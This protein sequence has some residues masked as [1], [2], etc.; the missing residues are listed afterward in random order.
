MKEAASKNHQ[1][2]YFTQNEKEVNSRMQKLFKYLLLGT[3]LFPIFYFV[4]L[5]EVSG[6][7]ICAFTGVV[8]GLI[9]IGAYSGKLVSDE[10]KVKWIIVNVYIIGGTIIFSMI[11]VNG[12]FMVIAPIAAA[13]LY[14]NKKL[15]I[16]TLTMTIA[17]YTVGDFV[18][19][20]L[21]LVYESAYKWIPL[22]LFFY[23]IQFIIIGAIL[24][25]LV[26]RTRLMVSKAQE[27]TEKNQEYLESSKETAQVVSKALE[28][29]TSNLSQ[30]NEIIGDVEGSAENMVVSSKDIVESAQNTSNIIKD[31]TNDIEKVVNQVEKT[32]IISDKMTDITNDNKKNISDFL[33]LVENIKDKSNY[34]KECM[35]SL[36]GMI[37]HIQSILEN[38]SDISS[39]T[40]LLALNASI[41]AARYGE[42]GKGFSV[43]AEEVKKLALE[44]N[45][46]SISIG[47]FTGRLEDETKKAVNAIDGNYNMILE[48]AGYISETNKSF[49]YLINIQNNMAE[50]INH[51][52]TIMDEFV[53]KTKVIEENINVLM[54]KNKNNDYEVS[55]IRNA[56]IDISNKSKAIE[57]GIDKIS[58]QIEY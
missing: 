14:Y 19:S 12:I 5:L 2:N 10:R 21:G 38:I 57:E 6:I 4:G 9:L 46:Y 8:I 29:A 23:V 51:V 37:E 54:E 45:K 11:S 31:V 26:K 7:A 42:S 47:E 36:Q 18:A 49:D 56:I 25:S 50:Q 52:N 53:Y 22:H 24:L 40:E 13:T 17:G 44:S 27:L 34:S 35:S 15:L 55:E 30:T 1:I 58:K 16:Y 28:K 33:E 32:N 41:E 39:Q 48:S 43:I 3:V 20:S